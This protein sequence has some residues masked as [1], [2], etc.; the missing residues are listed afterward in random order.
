[1]KLLWNFFELSNYT[2][3]VF[4]CQPQLHLMYVSKQVS[5]IAYINI[6][7]PIKMLYAMF[8]KKI[9]TMCNMIAFECILTNIEQLLHRKQH[10]HFDF[11]WK[12]TGQNIMVIHFITS[13]FRQVQRISQQLCFA[14]NQSL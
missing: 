9:M 14:S 6:G 1:M 3:E 12:K 11:I 8:D 10:D 4:I 7:C 2:Q 5:Q 13:L